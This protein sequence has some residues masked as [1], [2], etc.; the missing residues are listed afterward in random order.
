MDRP[1]L[2]VAPKVAGNAWNRIRYTLW[3]PL[4]DV[5]GRRFDAK[6]RESLRMLDARPGERILIVG[7][8]TGADLPYVP[9][10]CTTLATDLT[11]AML[12]RARAHL[13]EGIHLAI[14][15]GHALGVPSASC[16]AVVLHLI[17]AVIPD[18]VRCLQ[19]VAR[20]LRPGGRVVVFD[21]FIRTRRP[22]VVLR[23]VN[24]VTS[25]LFTDVTRRFED[26]LERSGA[27]L[28]IEDDKAALFKG[29]FRH[30]QLRKTAPSRP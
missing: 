2:R 3:A 9:E 7:A 4:Y 15:D 8:G 1:E 29:L 28:V 20:V 19:E 17:L 10:G 25:A 5:V 14:M 23:L 26:I 6:R 13:R 16:D 24:I 18:P 12:V 22:P 27:P 30:I 11:P 21:K